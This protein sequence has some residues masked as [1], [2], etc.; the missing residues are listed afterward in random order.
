MKKFAVRAAVLS[1]AGLCAASAGAQPRVPTHVACVGDSITHGSGASSAATTYP[2]ILQTLLGA[3]AHVQ[4]FG[5]SGATMLS[6]GN[7]PYVAQPEYTAATTFVSNAGATAL[8]DVIIMLGSNDSKP[9]NWTP[10]GG[11]GAAAFQADYAAMVDHFTSLSTHPVVYLALPPTA[12]ANTFGISETVI[13]DQMI[14]VIVQVAGKKGMPVIDVN[15]PTAGHPS[16]FVDGIHPNDMGYALVAQVMRDGLLGPLQT[17][18]GAFEAGAPDSGMLPSDGAALSPESGAP[19][20]DAAAALESGAPISDASVLD[21]AD[22]TESGAPSVD[23]GSG[24]DTASRGGA[25]APPGASSGCALGDGPES[26]GSRLPAAVWLAAG[27]LY[28]VARRR[29]PRG[30]RIR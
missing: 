20:D 14:P 17:D 5:H 30:R 3:G 28:L 11:N 7:L 2:A 15:T 6:K 16:Y 10:D 9:V 29:R 18:A 4:N 23:S 1:C 26:A 21:G 27:A 25:A 19:S 22:P 24:A 13:H 12:Y 8:V